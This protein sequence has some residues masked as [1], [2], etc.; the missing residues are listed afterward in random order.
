MRSDEI[1]IKKFQH[2]KKQFQR[3][4]QKNKSK[5]SRKKYHMS[6]FIQRHA[7]RM[8]ALITDKAKTTR[9]IF[10]KSK[11]RKKPLFNDKKHIIEMQFHSSKKNLRHIRTQ[12]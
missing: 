10:R 12:F 2:Y 6:I 1:M 8:I 4:F 11:D 9:A 7:R 5:K 3:I